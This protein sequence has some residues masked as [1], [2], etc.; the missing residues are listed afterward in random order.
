MHNSTNKILNNWPKLWGWDPHFTAVITNT[1]PCP[2]SVETWVFWTSINRFD[3][4]VTCSDREGSLIAESKG[5]DL[6]KQFW[7][8]TAFLILLRIT[9]LKQ[10]G[11]WK[12]SEVAKT[13]S[14]MYNVHTVKVFRL[15][16]YLI[17]WKYRGCVDKLSR[18]TLEIQRNK[19]Y[20]SNK[21]KKVP[22]K[23]AEHNFGSLWVHVI[24][25]IMARERLQLTSWNLARLGA[26]YWCT[27]A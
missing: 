16:I 10:R 18:S 17:A 5:E 7:M 19:R 13:L 23:V 8:T 21:G 22:V 2:L 3:G 15:F 1:H 26:R 4:F 11:L 12:L 27:R 25:Q 14:I 6:Q 20:H 24:C 9:L